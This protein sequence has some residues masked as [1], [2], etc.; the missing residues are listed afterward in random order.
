M[1]CRICLKLDNK[2]PHGSQFSRSRYTKDIPKLTA[3]LLLFGSPGH[4]FSINKYKRTAVL[5]VFIKVADF[6]APDSLLTPFY[7][8]RNLLINVFDKNS[9]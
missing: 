9:F 4:V 2:S 6:V 3:K 5:S 1:E 8:E 7:L